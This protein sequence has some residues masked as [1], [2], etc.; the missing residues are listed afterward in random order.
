MVEKKK[1]EQIR[2]FHISYDTHLHEQAC[3][4][5]G[6]DFGVRRRVEPLELWHGDVVAVQDADG[7]L[8]TM[9]ATVIGG[10]E[11]S[12]HLMENVS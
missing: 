6:V 7:T 8:I 12:H 9:S 5:H 2:V 1:Q 3:I 11:H 10:A 4:H